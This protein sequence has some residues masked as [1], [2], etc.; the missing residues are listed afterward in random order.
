MR[1][2]WQAAYGPL[3]AVAFT[4][5]VIAGAKVFAQQNAGPNVIGAGTY[6]P[7]FTAQNGHLSIGNGAAPSV[8]S[9]CGTSPVAPQGTDS[10]YFFTSGTSSSSGCQ[11]TPATPWKQRPSCSVDAQA[12]TQP[13]WSVGPTGVL[14]L[15]GVADS[16]TYNV[17]CIGQPGG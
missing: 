4:L 1:R 8:N 17:I 9:A 15:T 16:T 10:A 6:G 12:A 7:P 5:C 3:V 11:V 2:F 14:N 13:A